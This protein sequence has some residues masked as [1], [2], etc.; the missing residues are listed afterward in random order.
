[1]IFPGPAM[2]RRRRH[3]CGR[4]QRRNVVDFLRWL[5]QLDP[6]VHR[7]IKGLRLVTSYAI[8]ALL[9]TVPDIAGALPDA[10]AL[11]P[12][13]GGFALWGSVSEGRATR[14]ESGRDLVLLTAAAAFGAASF[15]AL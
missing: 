6:G 8:A 1:M 12:L 15:V 13:A 10:R 9:G 14:A 4:N 2:R 7:R 11:V 5:D 3:V